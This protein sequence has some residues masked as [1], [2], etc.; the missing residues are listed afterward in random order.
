MIQEEGAQFNATYSNDSLYNRTQKNESP[1]EVNTL[2][3]LLSDGKAVYEYDLRG[4]QVRKNT[5]SQQ[6]S[7]SYDPLNELIEVKS[8]EEKT[9]FHL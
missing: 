1:C 2:S 8:G 5:G 3:E 9:Q 4:N 7:F 6:L